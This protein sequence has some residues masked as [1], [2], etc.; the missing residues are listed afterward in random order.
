MKYVVK[1]KDRNTEEVLNCAEFRHKEPAQFFFRKLDKSFG[2][3]YDF[4]VETQP[5]T[6]KIIKSYKTE[7]E[8]KTN[9]GK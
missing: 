7:K 1:G 2:K 5:G 6:T 9:V 3:V 4:W 8:N